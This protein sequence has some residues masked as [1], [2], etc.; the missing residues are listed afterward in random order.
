MLEDH[1]HNHPQFQTNH[2]VKLKQSIPSTL[3]SNCCTISKAL[4]QHTFLILARQQIE[5]RRKSLEI[6]KAKFFSDILQGSRYSFTSGD[7]TH[8]LLQKETQ[9]CLNNILRPQT[10]QHSS[11]KRGKDL[12]K[13]SLKEN[14]VEVRTQT[15]LIT[16][17]RINI[18]FGNMVLFSALKLSSIGN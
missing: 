17:F 7:K 12:Q 8:S 11:Y 15:K 14:I 18:A 10:N 3:F 13:Q 1:G 4:Y 5:K 9:K 2:K 6:E 16:K